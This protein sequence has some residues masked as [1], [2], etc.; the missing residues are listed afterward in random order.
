MRKLHP[1][2]GMLEVIEES[3]LFYRMSTSYD[4]WVPKAD[5]SDGKPTEATK[6]EGG[7]G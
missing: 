3:P 1:R 6:A 7:E 2:L 5:F 4:F